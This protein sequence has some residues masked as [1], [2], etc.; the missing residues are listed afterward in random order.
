MAIFGVRASKT[1]HDELLQNVFRAPLFFFDTTPTGRIISRF[2]KDLFSIDSELSETFDF[3]LWGSLYVVISLGTITF[4]TPWFGVAIV[5]IGVV[6]LRVL[7]YF[8][9]VSRETKRLESI[10]RSP[11]YAHFS[12]SLGGLA[13]I[14]AY[15]QSQRFINVFLR[16]VDQNTRAYFNI[17][18]ADRWLSVRLEL[19]GSIVAGLA[20]ICAT[21]VSVSNSTSGI[22]T[23]SNFA[24]LAGLSLSYAISVTGVMNW[25]VRSFANLE[26]GMNATERV[27]YYSEQIPQE[28]AATTD[29][30][31][32]RVADMPSPPPPSEPSA[33]AVA[34]SGGTALRPKRP[35]PENGAITLTN[36]FMRYR[37]DTPIV[38]KGLNL[39]I[40]GGEKI[41][42]KFFFCLVSFL[43]CLA[44]EPL[45]NSTSLFPL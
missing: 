19:L 13:T 12:E 22:S 33:F 15:G 18:V 27:L 1:L 42:G 29:T 16:K 43:I 23:G 4:A 30:L 32:A 10:S 37:K 20:A 44:I 31:E 35:W 8:R 5:P 3:F 41:G 17:K 45:L 7:N 14:R 34:A 2:S 11:V 24:S 40:S 38:L 9:D 28:A 6:Y 21:Y 25:C 36:L 26:A 39:S